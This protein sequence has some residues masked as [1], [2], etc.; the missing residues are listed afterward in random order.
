MNESNPSLKDW[1]QAATA[2]LPPSAVEKFR[3]EIEDHAAEARRKHI[4]QGMPPDEA[5][6]AALSGL[7]DAAQVARTFRDAHFSRR[8]YSR[9]MIAVLV[10][11]LIFASTI[12][13]FQIWLSSSYD[14]LVAEAFL[15]SWQIA[16]P[17]FHLVSVVALVFGA[18][19]VIVFLN[20]Q[21]DTNIS[22]RWRIVVTA[23]ILLVFVP[24]LLLT[25]AAMTAP[26]PD[27]IAR[28][29][30]LR[31]IIAGIF[32][33]NTWIAVN[34]I[35]SDCHLISSVTGE[36]LIVVFCVRQLAARP[37]G[38]RPILSLLLILGGLAAV[39]NLLPY[40][41]SILRGHG[42]L[43]YA[44]YPI[45]GVTRT[46]AGEIFVTAINQLPG[47]EGVSNF[48]ALV[49]LVGL[50]AHLRRPGAVVAR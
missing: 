29:T 22:R 1:I 13:V 40:S 28:V 11:T 46:E 37:L 6:R 27:Q 12:V 30:G 36:V 24:G 8:A 31:P 49:M 18:D 15:E 25:F 9:G 26:L 5:D 47:V 35:A 33:H 7:G 21:Y 3:A 14:P 19:A 38:A 43:F 39:A 23:L 34:Q 45:L 4:E 32:H 20:E 10:Y 2:G 42:D 48:V 16:G 50:F 44:L 17:V 41:W